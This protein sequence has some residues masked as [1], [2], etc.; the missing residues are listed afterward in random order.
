MKPYSPIIIIGAPRSGTNMLRDI[1]C[2]VERVGTWPCDEINYIW[3]HGNIKNSTDEFD[4]SMARPKVIKFI[5]N[6]FERFSRKNK[7][8]YVVEKTC[9]NSLRVA[10]VEKIFPEAKYVFIVRDGIDVAGSATLK[11]RAKLDILYLMKKA[12]YVPIFDLPYLAF[13]YFGNRIYKVFSKE[14]RLSIWGPKFKGINEAFESHHL[15]EACALQWQRC[16]LMADQAFEEIPEERVIRVK[17]EDLVN[18]PIREV[19]RILENLDID[20]NQKKVKDS[21]RLVTSSNIGK[22][23][24]ALDKERLKSI[25]SLVSTTLKKYGYK[26]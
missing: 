22:G 1:L 15:E 2:Q 23:R 5:R 12:R 16:V 13:Q 25:L 20:F 21:V 24:I 18:S 9:A 19:E 17:Y 3:R 11:W 4:H 6:V 7:L 10:F 8:D 26:Y 14:K